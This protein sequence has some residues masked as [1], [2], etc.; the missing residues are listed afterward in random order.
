MTSIGE[1]LE[2]LGSSCILSRNLSCCSR[3]GK[4][5]G[6]FSEKLKTELPCDSAIQRR[7]LKRY[8]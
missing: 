8:L 5:Y 2:N 1:D 3:Y 6:P 7:D 4:L